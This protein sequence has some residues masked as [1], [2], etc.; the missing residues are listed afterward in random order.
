MSTLVRQRVRLETLGA[1]GFVDEPAAIRF[2]FRTTVC[3]ASAV[4]AHAMFLRPE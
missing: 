2:A 3:K 4:L 1:G